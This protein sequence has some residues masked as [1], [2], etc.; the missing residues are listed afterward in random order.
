MENEMHFESILDEALALVQGGK[1]VPE[2]LAIFPEYHVELFGLLT[3]A[4]SLSELRDE[5]LSSTALTRT[6]NLLPSASSQAQIP[7]ASSVKNSFS[8][9]MKKLVWLRVIGVGAFAVLVG[10]MVVNKYIQNQYAPATYLP[11][12]YGNGNLLSAHIPQGD[13]LSVD[14]VGT[15]Y[16]AQTGLASTDVRVTVARLGRLA[17][18]FLDPVGSA[19]VDGG[20][21]IAI[22]SL[23]NATNDSSFDNSISDQ[24]DTREFLKTGYNATVETREVQTLGNRAATIIRGYG[25]RIDSVSLS[26]EYGYISFVVPADT[27]DRFRAEIQ[28]LVGKRFYDETINM[29]NLLP[30]KQQVEQSTDATIGA[31]AIIQN[32]ITS[33]TAERDA[34]L[35][36]LRNSIAGINYIVNQ[37]NAAL[38]VATDPEEINRLTAD[39]NANQKIVQQTRQ[40]LTEVTNYYANELQNL[41]TQL[42]N[43]QGTL[44]NLQTQN[45]NILNDVATV[46]GTITFKW[47]SIP[48][49][50]HRYLPYFYIWLPALVALIIY[51]R[52]KRTKTM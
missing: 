47:I 30:Q 9:R 52:K 21:A 40:R 39:R 1:S 42:Q 35:K 6:L 23:V 14:D 24:T 19:V 20:S 31:Q 2:V 15:E 33:V 11:V 38:A 7:A 45:Q 51:W 18:S 34:Y 13:Q 8:E 28:S 37:D 27:F 5:I 3:T 32:Q 46:Q 17:S 44:A 25:G 10:F 50:L 22:N 29:T 49:V 16:A 36:N 4:S 48:L 41:Q 26:K 12:A 43:T